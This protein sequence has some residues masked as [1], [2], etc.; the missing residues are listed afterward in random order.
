MRKAV[1]DAGRSVPCSGNGGTPA[2]ASFTV[3]F[4]DLGLHHHVAGLALGTG[5]GV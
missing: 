2:A 3:A 1:Q 5:K 4:R